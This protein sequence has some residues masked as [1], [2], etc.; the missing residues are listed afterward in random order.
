MDGNDANLKQ[1]GDGSGL[2]TDMQLVFIILILTA[3]FFLIPRFRSDMV[4]LTSLLALFL[5]DILTIEETFSGFANSVVIMMGALFIVGEGVL[6]TGLAEKAGNL[7]AKYTEDSEFKM[8]IGMMLLVAI[9]SGFM[10]NT[11]T[12]AILLPV[13]V[14][15]CRKIQVHPGKLLMPLAFVSSI[16]GSLTLIGTAPNLIASQSLTDYGYEPLG[17][18]S[19]APIA[20]VV[21]IVGML[22]LWYIGRKLLQ[23]PFKENAATAEDTDKDLLKLY[24][25]E[26]HLHKVVIPEFFNPENES[27]KELKWASTYEVTVLEAV[28]EGRKNPMSLTKS[29]PK[30]AVGAD[31]VP[32]PRDVLM[33]YGDPEALKRFQEDTGIKSVTTEEDEKYTLDT[34]RIAE[35]ILT[36]HSNYINRRIKQIQ[37]RDKYDLTILAL[38]PQYKKA[39]KPDGD[40]KLTYG[41]TLLVYGEWKDI[42]LLH[43]EMEDTVVLSHRKELKNRIYSPL[44]TIIAGLI[45]L[46]MIVMMVFQI[47]PVS[48]TVLIAALLMVVTR[49]IPQVDQAYRGVNWQTIILIA[50]M[51]PMAT[52]L[53]KTGGI[54]VISDSLISLLGNVG[55]LAVMA[56]LYGIASIFS[57]F[58]SNTA[59]AVL[60]YPVAILT[61]QNMAVSPYPMVMAVAFAASMAFA[62]PVATPP[63]A[64]VMAAGKYRFLDF[65]KVGSPLQLIIGIC[66]VAM[67][68]LFFPF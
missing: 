38:K 49:S 13:I 36:P 22:Y 37:F 63:N 64:M 42:D 57:Q 23:Q 32:K 33:V 30:K 28:T 4:A 10:N 67:L 58:I 34:S 20:S 1:K 52:A 53:E 31:Y 25:V 15:L 51:L 2:F 46:F 29:T 24:D 59:T 3:L 12:I 41:D 14:S 60:L 61:A 40:R 35:V 6:R 68:P 11:G 27:L 65:I 43:E 39:L 17:F 9:L 7:I 47:L 21:L 16:G 54:E 50:C 62:T 45:L 8:T 56:G 44:H 18:L 26:K 5:T 66:I 55:P 19:F 48:I